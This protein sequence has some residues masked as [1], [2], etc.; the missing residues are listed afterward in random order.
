MCKHKEELDLVI[1]RNMKELKIIVSIEISWT[2][3]DKYQ[4]F[5]LGGN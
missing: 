4:M 2:Q 1:W 3:E 5:S